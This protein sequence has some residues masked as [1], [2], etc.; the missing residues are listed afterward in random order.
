MS[1]ITYRDLTTLEEFAA[2]VQLERD[3]WGPSYDDVVPVPIL[4]VS[5][6][7]G[8]ILIGAFDADRMIGFVYSLPAIKDTKPTQWSHMA[9][10]VTEY[11][12][13]GIGA[14]LKLLQR[15]R[16]LSAGLELVQW[17]YDP[18]QAM[19]AHLNFA[20]L[21]VVCDEYAVN[22]YGVSAS[23]LHGGNPTDRFVA[24][25]WIRTPRVE[26]RLRGAAPLAP[27]MTVE[28]AGRARAEGKWL[29]PAAIDLSLEVRRISVEIPTGFTE[30]LASAPDLALEWRLV[31]RGIFTT[32]FARGYRAVEFFLDRPGRKGAY[33]LVRT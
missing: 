6:H 5:V 4:A 22:I 33:L 23:P 32:Y 28:P 1:S 26:D 18:L 29:N 17:T 19:N 8:G 7:S 21:G 3:I 16:A 2:V 24:D 27:V 30:M 12:G 9:G 14:Q 13:G 25:W 20:K 10:V 31:T 15:E 11:Q